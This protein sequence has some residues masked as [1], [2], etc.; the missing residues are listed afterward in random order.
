MPLAFPHP[1]DHEL[2]S[3]SVRLPNEPRFLL[4]RALL[5]ISGSAEAGLI[6]RHG[7]SVGAELVVSR[8]ELDDI[9]RMIEHRGDKNKK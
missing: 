2:D 4:R 1:F 3:W 6:A 8:K 5:D 9:R 7:E